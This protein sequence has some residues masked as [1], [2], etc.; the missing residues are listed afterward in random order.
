VAFLDADSNASPNRQKSTGDRQD[1][2]WQLSH[3][4]S[5]HSVNPVST[6]LLFDRIN[7]INKIE[8]N[9][10]VKSAHVHHRRVACRRLFRACRDFSAD[11]PK[12]S[13]SGG[14]HPQLTV[15]PPIGTK[16]C[17]GD[18]LALPPPGGFLG[19]ENTQRH[20]QSWDLSNAIGKFGAAGPA[21]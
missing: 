16:F 13:S 17:S 15:W 5:V 1:A 2:A 11:D 10:L 3:F 4:N 20:C 19:F 8:K 7:R 14:A 12:P 18:L 6:N 9:E 21:K